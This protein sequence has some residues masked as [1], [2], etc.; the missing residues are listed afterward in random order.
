MRTSLILGALL[1]VCA[2]ILGAV[3]LGQLT[4]AHT[5]MTITETTLAGDP[6][7]AE[8]LHVTLTTQRENQLFWTT[9][10]DAGTAPQLRTEFTYFYSRQHEDYVP[11]DR[12]SFQLGNLN[13]GFG[14][15]FSEEDLRL[16]D[17][18][19]KWFGPREG[20]MIKP[21]MELARKVPAGQTMTE[22]VRLR[23]YYEAYRIGWYGPDPVDWE[24]LCELLYVPVPED[25]LL[26]VSVTKD[27]YGNADMMETYPAEGQDQLGLWGEAF[28][29]GQDLYLYLAREE[30]GRE[31]LTQLPLGYGLYRIPLN[32]EGMA[33]VAKAENVYPLDPVSE[34][35]RQVERSAD[36]S[37]LY[38]QI[39]DEQGMRLV[40]WNLQTGAA[41]Q[42]FPLEGEQTFD[43]WMDGELLVLQDYNEETS[44]TRI[45][46]LRK[47]N[48]QY[49]LWLRTDLYLLT[50]EGGWYG[51]PSLAFDGNRLAI[52]AY[53]DTWTTCSHRIQVYT[54]SGL[55]YAG[56]YAHS[57]DALEN[58][59]WTDWPNSL[60]LT[61]RG[62]A[63]HGSP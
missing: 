47:Q 25:L 61:W 49:A 62:S 21:L 8:G 12:F 2:L 11:D 29:V 22:T 3:A 63:S 55:Q 19:D 46:A 28:P 41:E 43:I 13:V 1:L 37:S 32:E 44:R 24:T 39:R 6:A 52:A 9:D 27:S 5:D 48:G 38:L 18:E 53:H 50:P 45:T 59:M 58:G 7:A 34:S 51:E 30:V 15:G 35:F 20:Y 56:D 17:E 23:D 36:G 60:Q 4:K 31:D 33:D 10:Y 57:N 40:I 14:G 16:M 26:T 42:A 54:Q